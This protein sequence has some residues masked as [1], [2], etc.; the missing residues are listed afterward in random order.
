VREQQLGRSLEELLLQ[1]AKRT[2]LGGLLLNQGKIA[3]TPAFLLVTDIALGKTP[4]RAGM[5]AI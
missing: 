3:V 1:M 2:S 5:V 4:A